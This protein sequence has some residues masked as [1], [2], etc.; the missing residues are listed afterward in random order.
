VQI[1]Q[2]HG[3]NFFCCMENAIRS[4]TIKSRGGIR[5]QIREKTEIASHARGRLDTVVRHQPHDE[6]RRNTFS[7][8]MIIEIRADECA[9]D[10]LLNDRLS[11]LRE[12]NIFDFTPS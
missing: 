9:V 10:A 4:L 1:R 12:N 2:G 6:Q 7:P 3:L 5:D 11:I 8:E